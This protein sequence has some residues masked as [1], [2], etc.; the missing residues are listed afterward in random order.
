[1]KI[2]KEQTEQKENEPIKENKVSDTESTDTEGNSRVI[3]QHAYSCDMFDF[4]GKN[5]GTL[6]KHENK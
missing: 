1:M 3:N 5:Q 6:K 2:E 4:K